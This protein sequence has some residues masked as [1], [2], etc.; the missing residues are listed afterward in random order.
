M[1]FDSGEI[2]YGLPF[3]PSKPQI[4]GNDPYDAKWVAGRRLLVVH[5]EAD[6]HLHLLVPHPPEHA[7]RV[8]GGPAELIAETPGEDS[9]L[10]EMMPVD[11]MPASNGEFIPRRPRAEQFRIMRLQDSAAEE[12]RR[13]MGLS[14]R[15]F[16]RSAAAYGARA[17]GDLAGDAQRVGLPTRSANPPGTGACDLEWPGRAAGQPARRVH[18]RHPVPPRRPGRHVAG[19]PTPASTPCFMALWEQSGPLGGMP[20]RYAD[21]KLHGFGQGGELDPIE[22]LSRFHYIKELFLDSSTNMTVLSAVPSSPEQQPLPIIEA[23]AH[24][25]HRQPARRRYAARG[26]ARVRHAQPWVRWRHDDSGVTPVFHAGRVRHDG[27]QRPA[28]RRAASRGWKVYTPVGRRPQRQRLVPRRRDRPGLP[29]PGARAA[30]R[31]RRAQRQSP[32]TRASR[33]RPS[34]SEPP[35]PRD[36]GPAARQNPDINF[37]VYHSGYDSETQTAYPGDDKVNSADRGVNSL[38]QERCAR[39]AGTPAASC[40]PAWRTATCPTCTPRSARRCAR[41]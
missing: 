30:R 15:S 16:V 28:L 7:R 13:R 6:R 36:I 22:N 2:G 17:L 23:A 21:G 39:T 24:G 29:R 9:S 31:L 4:G 18:L 1:D 11:V 41:S 32:A 38:H 34:T 20:G 12:L 8:Q 40:R 37:I 35:R 14:R 5:A 25:R 10:S 27:A 19:R 26:D 3:E 33:C